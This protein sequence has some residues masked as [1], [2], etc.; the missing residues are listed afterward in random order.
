[1]TK[2]K[3]IRPCFEYNNHGMEKDLEQILRHEKGPRQGK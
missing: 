1:M 3:P 2:P